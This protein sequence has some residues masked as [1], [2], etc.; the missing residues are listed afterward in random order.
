[1]C[2]QINRRFFVELMTKKKKF[3]NT[4]LLLIHEKGFKSMTMRDL[5]SRMSCDIKNLYNYTPSKA[6]LLED[7]LFSISDD[8]HKGINHI[9]EAEL[10]PVQQI[11]ELIRL[12]VELSSSKPLQVG[13]LI[14][15]W[16]SLS[17]SEPF[18]K[19]RLAY[20]H[21]VSS[22]LENGMVQK[23]FRELNI[24]ITTQYIL[25]SLRWQYSYYIETKE[26][27]NPLAAV[28]SLKKLILPGL[29]FLKK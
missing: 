11:E 17:D 29:L 2:I 22:I 5:A 8:F 21:K 7:L 14:N 1:M 16:K 6:A 4:A 24:G 26:I 23:Q 19:K 10:S 27:H 9:L 20:E 3:Q 25:G 28:E 12:H 18:T 15:D 13:L